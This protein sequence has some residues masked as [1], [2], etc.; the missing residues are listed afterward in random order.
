M[1]YSYFEAGHVDHAYAMTV[2]KAQGLTCDRA[3]VLGTDDLY[4]EAGYTA[5]SRGRYENRLYV[6]A[7]DEPNVDHHGVIE[8][9]NP[10]EGIRTALQRSERQQLATR[11]LFALAGERIAVPAK[12]DRYGT[13]TP[14]Q[15]APE[16]DDGIDLGL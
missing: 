3:Y 12:L 7:H 6:T 16:H 15:D 1:P 11:Q 2:H 5:L 9:D 14:A 13:D 4:A 8:D 10:I